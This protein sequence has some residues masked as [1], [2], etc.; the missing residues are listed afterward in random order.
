[1]AAYQ[2]QAI[3]SRRQ[4]SVKPRLEKKYCMVHPIKEMNVGNGITIRYHDNQDR[5]EYKDYLSIEVM[6]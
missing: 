1:M 2:L 6:T 5:R 4:H 3:A